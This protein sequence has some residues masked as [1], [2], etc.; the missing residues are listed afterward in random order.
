MKEIS[1]YEIIE[2]KYARVYTYMKILG[3]MEKQILALAIEVMHGWNNNT[4]EQAI[5]GLPQV[6]TPVAGPMEQVWWLPF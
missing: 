2:R 1:Y 4:K 3:Q 5:P 6:P